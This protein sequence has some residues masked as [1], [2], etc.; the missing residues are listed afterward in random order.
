V[1][2]DTTINPIDWMWFLTFFPSHHRTLIS[3]RE[4]DINN[5]PPPRC[6]PPSP[7]P[8]RHH[9]WMLPMNSF[10][11]QGH[12]GAMMMLAFEIFLFVK[13]II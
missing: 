13:N 12:A 1:N 2:I 4:V 5:L 9:D 3:N 7:L 11:S 8:S 10:G 6:L